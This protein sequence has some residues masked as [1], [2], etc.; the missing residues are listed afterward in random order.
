MLGQLGVFKM[1]CC[2]QMNCFPFGVAVMFFVFNK[3]TELAVSLSFI[4][5]WFQSIYLQ[6]CW[7]ENERAKVMQDVHIQTDPQ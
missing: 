2:Q 3:G 5:M 7:I 4:R 6:S 1:V